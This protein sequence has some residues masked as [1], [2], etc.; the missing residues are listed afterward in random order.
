MFRLL[1]QWEL[2]IRVKFFLPHNSESYTP[3]TTSYLDQEPQRCGETD[4]HT[5]DCI[6]VL[7]LI[8]LRLRLNYLFKSNY[9]HACVAYKLWAAKK[10]RRE[11]NS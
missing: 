4:K 11:M 7:S 3:L 5:G 1:D 8:I 10:A 6:R 9:P 2:E